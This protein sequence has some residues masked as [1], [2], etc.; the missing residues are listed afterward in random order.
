MLKLLKICIYLSIVPAFG[1]INMFET[2]E[3]KYIL[4]L[5][6]DAFPDLKFE[7][8][9]DGKVQGSVNAGLTE[10]IDNKDY[11]KAFLHFDEAIV[12]LPSC[13]P[14]FY[15]RGICYKLSNKFDNA[16]DDLSKASALAPDRPE[17][18]LELAEVY[19]LQYA[20]DGAERL[21]EKAIELDPA[22]VDA[23]YNLANLSMR[24]R[25]F[26]KATKFFK[27]S[28]AIDP[29]YIKSH[30]RQGILAYALDKKGSKT[31]GHFNNALAIDSTFEAALFWRGMMN[32]YDKNVER[33]LEDWNKLVLYNPEDPLF[34]L[35]RAF[36]YLDLEDF[37]KAFIDLKNVYSKTYTD[38]NAFRG[39]QSTADHRLDL[40][41]AVTYINRT[42][43]GLDDEAGSHLKSGFCF[44]VM[45]RRSEASNQ[46]K[47]SFALQPSSLALFLRALNYEHANKH[48]SAFQMYQEALK[49]DNDIFD[50]HKKMAIYYSELKDWRSCYRH[51]E[52][53]IRLEPAMALTYRLRAIVKI[54]FKDHYGAILDLTRYIAL[55]S[56]DH[57]IYLFRAYCKKAVKDLKGE[58]QD[59]RKA[60]EI[61]PGDY[62]LYEYVIRSDLHLKDTSHAL[63]TLAI[64]EKKFG[65]KTY[66]FST[67]VRIFIHQKKFEDARKELLKVS[68]D[69]F[70]LS[71]RPDPE[72]SL[73][74]FL[75]GWLDYLQNDHASAIRKL[76][77]AITHNAQ[78]FEAIYLRSKIYT[79]RGDRMR[80][81]ND[82]KI[83][84]KAGYSDSE[85]L[86][87]EL[88]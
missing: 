85:I 53:M 16:K 40:Q 25:L 73:L 80:A 88:K 50:A 47:K 3:N 23:Y 7:W 4:D 36:L 22:F 66:V 24:Q 87:N 63:T 39:S 29:S 35:L 42:I 56:T 72:L 78:N 69:K 9:F 55:D 1:Q 54:E 41:Y 15:Y 65:I 60:L 17:I 46:F 11:E 28:L 48:D 18:L 82:L 13:L 32:L 5:E 20:Y 30:V 31:I 10:L 76:S 33:C 52:N 43:Y 51:F 37:E 49:H 71:M 44:M 8:N 27:K 83:L 74:H 70:W 19:E 45:E 59:Y 26:P 6:L 86:L 2:V 68:G 62:D 38:E 84:A 79:A 57:D 58:N 64:C 75:D 21:Y 67:K 61:N 14:A 81:L 77:K 34:V 12:K